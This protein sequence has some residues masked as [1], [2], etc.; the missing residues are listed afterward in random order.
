MELAKRTTALIGMSFSV[1]AFPTLAQF[2]AQDDRENF[3]KQIIA[4]ARQ[5][6]FWSIPV[7]VFFIVLRAHIVRVILG[8]GFFSWSDTRLTAAALALFVVSVAF[9]GLILLLV[10]GYYAAGKTWR[11]LWITLCGAGV[12]MLAAFFLLHLFNTNATFMLAVEKMLRVQG[13]P[14]TPVLMLALAY[15]I[16]EAIR[17]LIMYTWFKRE[18]MQ[19]Y[20]TRLRVVF[21][22]SAIASLCMGFVMY[23]SLQ[24]FN[25]FFD[26]NTFKGVFMQGFLS[27]VI[28]I[29]VLVIGLYMLGNQE[30]KALIF[31]LRDKGFWKIQTP[32]TSK[33]EVL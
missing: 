20:V 27:G 22:Q 28:G 30:I 14:G 15:S 19:G 26:I 32:E 2:F 25:M 6:I 5:I 21:F 12:S 7:I 11:P 13:V 24:F 9:Q 4:P 17:F 1:A 33:E 3:L 31:A 29:A 8:A 23:H 18:F 16:G 10:R